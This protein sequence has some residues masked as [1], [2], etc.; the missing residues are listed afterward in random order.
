MIRLIQ[1]FTLLFILFLLNCSSIEKP[2]GIRTN[3]YNA[4][5][6]KMVGFADERTYCEILNKK[7]IV[8]YLF[9]L[10]F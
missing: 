7:K 1:I 4:F 3:S 5:S 9:V 2:F 8:H 10:P 6:Y